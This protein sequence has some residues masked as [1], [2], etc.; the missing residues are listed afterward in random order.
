LHRVYESLKPQTFRD[1]EWLIADNGSSDNTQELVNKWI[2]EADFPI[3]LIS[4]KNNVGFNGAINRGIKEAQGKFF[5][6]LDSDDTCT[7][8]TLEGF[9]KYWELIPNDIKENFTGVTSLCVDQ[10]GNMVCGKY[11]EDITDSDALEMKYKYKVSGEMWGFNK[12]DVL[13]QYH[14]PEKESTPVSIVWSQIGRKYKTRFINQ[15]F[16]TW[17][18]KEPGRKDQATYDRPISQI[19]VGSTLVHLD[20]LNNDIDWFKYSPKEFFRSATHYTRFSLHSGIR[21]LDQLKKL[22]N[23]LAI[24]LW[25]IMTPV[26]FLVFIKDRK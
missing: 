10:H 7:E 18:I 19:A 12:T 26:G 14:F 17:Y 23:G 25:L 13:K 2:Q 24:F 6:A 16:R 11:P 3:R 4:W 5:L 9:K 20:I 22:N 15:I 21:F 1:F 8:N